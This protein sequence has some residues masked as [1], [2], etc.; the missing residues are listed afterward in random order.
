MGYCYD[1]SGRLCCDICNEAGGARKMR[2]P[3]NYCQPIACCDR[4]ACRDKL[5]QHRRATCASKCK[6]ANEQ[7]ME[8]E[9]E[10]KRRLDAGE[11][12]RCAALSESHFARC[13]RVW[14]RNKAGVERI[15]FMSDDTY[16]AFPLRASV[17]VEQYQG[18]GEVVDSPK[19]FMPGEHRCHRPRQLN[20]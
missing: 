2:C 6:L 8:E 13:V 20:P 12:L 18:M 3:Y 7:F 9:A 17:S 1:N 14:F 4:D 10:K 16:D 11:F 19:D 5:R 15:M